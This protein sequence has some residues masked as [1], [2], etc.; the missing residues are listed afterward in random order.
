MA[1][2]CL[3]GGS[4]RELENLDLCQWWL[5]GSSMEGPLLKS[6]AYLCGFYHR[7]EREP[8]L[9]A[10]GL[11]FFSSLKDPESCSSGPICLGKCMK[12]VPC[13]DLGIPYGAG[14]WGNIQGQGAWLFWM[15][16]L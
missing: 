10:G 5:P 12:V 9:G 4:N 8:F 6:N 1:D 3:D 7:E 2:I 11:Q 16:S 14:F 15:V 13:A